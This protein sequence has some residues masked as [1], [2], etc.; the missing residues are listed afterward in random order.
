M[1]SRFALRRLRY[2]IEFQPLEG[3]LAFVC[4]MWSGYYNQQRRN[5]VRPIGYIGSNVSRNRDSYFNQDADES[6]LDQGHPNVFW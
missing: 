6:S 3:W 1:T 4:K 2:A 5:S